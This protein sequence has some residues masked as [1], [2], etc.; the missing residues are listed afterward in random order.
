MVLSL[1]ALSSCQLDKLSE[2]QPA[3]PNHLHRSGEPHLD[4]SLVSR[5]PLRKLLSRDLR[6]NLGW[7]HTTGPDSKVIP[8]A[9]P[10]KKLS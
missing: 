7:F 5:W 1:N 6:G 3:C 4:C 2:G 9:Y 8:Y 10:H